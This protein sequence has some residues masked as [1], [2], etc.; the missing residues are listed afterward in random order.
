V[1]IV[2]LHEGR[3]EILVFLLFNVSDLSICWSDDAFTN[4]SFGI[5]EENEEENK[6]TKNRDKKGE[7][8]K[9][10]PT[11]YGKKYAQQ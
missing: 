8:P 3:D 2:D 10:K 5:A 11:E 7:E 6:N 9:R 4:I 1:N